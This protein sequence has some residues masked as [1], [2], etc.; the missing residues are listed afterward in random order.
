MKNVNRTLLQGLLLACVSVSALAASMDSSN[1]EGV[2]AGKAA[3]G[4]TTGDPN[5]YFKNYSADAPQKSYYGGGT[6]TDTNMDVL[7]QKELSTSE[8]GQSARESY[9]NNPADK[10]S[11]DSDMIKLSD[12]IRN[13]ADSLTGNQCVAQELS[14]T[15]WTTHSCEMA[16]ELKQTCTRRATIGTTGSRETYN[17]QLVLNAANATG[18]NLSD[19]W[20]Q[21]DLTVPENG[22]ISSGKWSFAYPSSPNYHGGRL[23]YSI[24]VFGQVV[25]AN[26][27][28]SGNL[29][30]SK[31]TV[32][33]G[34]II[35]LQ[36]RYNT[37]G[38]K[39]SGRDS[40][41]NSVSNGRFVIRVVF[42]M[43]AVRD[44]VKATINWTD[45]CPASMGD[46]VKLS[47]VCTEAGGNRSVTVGG[48]IYTLYSDCW[49]YTTTW[50]VYENDTNTCQALIKD[51]NC[52]EGTRTCTQKIGN[53]C[54]FQK[55]TYQC[56][57]T[58]KSTGYLC[59][60][61]FY[62]SDG[63]CASMQA[64]KN[65][66][67]SEAVS[68]LAALAAAGK[69]FAG[70]DANAARAFTGKPMFCRQS[71]AGFSNCCKSGGWGQSAGLAHCNTEEKAIGQAKEKQLTVSVGSFC[72]QKVLGVCL[73]KKEGY[74]VFDNKIARIVQEQGRRDQ[75]R[76]GFGSASSPDCRGIQVTELQNIKFDRIDFTDLYNELN[77]KV[78]L[79]DQNKL[80]QRI[81][82][83]IQNS[84][85]KGR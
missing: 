71:A 64:G 43:E 37:D 29:N 38:H 5:N 60:S 67:F 24:R 84:L 39:D 11:A 9:V 44:T 22:T 32:K 58:E 69:D 79:P 16:S 74:C 41:K 66:N 63:N 47:E 36:I 73:Q 27:N 68:Q 70:M 49:G 48:G 13:K 25:G 40:M 76:V 31:Q 21:Y 61:E 14:K 56:A 65:Q 26:L 80:N 1:Q 7:G 28:T 35:S 59:G 19:Y 23:N 42:P 18:R 52:S 4:T 17:T 57:H 3:S 50:S 33:K 54:V 83:D 53:L 46:A 15:T 8:L 62:C 2:N 81:T 20:V 55:M 45:S 85:N 51:R 12:D 78:K 6:Q 10:I 77:S 75:L 82:S 30:I 72:S 34:Q